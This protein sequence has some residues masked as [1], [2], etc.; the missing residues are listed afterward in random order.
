[1]IC[2]AQLGTVDVDAR[3][4]VDSA[5]RQKQAHRGSIMSYW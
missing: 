1:M 5:L 4:R 2:N 3:C